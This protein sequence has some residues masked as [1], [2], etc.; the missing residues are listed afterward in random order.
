MAPDLADD[1]ALAER[2]VRTASGIALASRG[3]AV[4]RKG[5]ATDVVTEADRRAEAALVD[6]LAAERPADGVVGEEGAAV[7][8]GGRRWLLDPVDG[9]LN[10]SVGIPVWCAAVALL[11]ANGALVAAV[12]DPVHDELFSA[13]RGCGAA[14][15]GAPVRVAVAP[16]LG[17]A[18]V[19][20]FVDARRRDDSVRAATSALARCVGAMRAAGSGTL[21]LAWVAAGRLHA[22]V[23]PD[24]EP[25]D[26]HPGALLV[27]EA[28]GVV[29]VRG[30]WHLAAGGEALA[31]ELEAL[32]LI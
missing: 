30:R 24:T 20:T 11:D 25:W 31:R 8:G 14:C 15:N 2:L 1:L 23:Q 26:W 12:H 7:A 21:E 28:G 4:E 6:L 29:R 32:L 3:G 13:A 10:F 9:T 18:V 19:A 22:W 27:A 16:P 17:D 5:L